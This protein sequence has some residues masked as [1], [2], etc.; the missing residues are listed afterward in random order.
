M[1]SSRSHLV[2]RDDPLPADAREL[3]KEIRYLAAAR[4]RDALTHPDNCTC[5]G[6]MIR[7]YD[8]ARPRTQAA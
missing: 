6:C 7:A 5:D 2:R 8:E 4:R 1:P 3:A